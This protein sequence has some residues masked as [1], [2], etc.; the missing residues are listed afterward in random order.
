VIDL[1]HINL[2]SMKSAGA[3]GEGVPPVIHLDSAELVGGSYGDGIPAGTGE[4]AGEGPEDPRKIGERGFQAGELPGAFSVERDLDVLNAPVTGK[5][6]SPENRF[7]AKQPLVVGVGIYSRQ[8]L[9][10][11]LGGPFSFLPVALVILIRHFDF[12][13]P[14]QLLDTVKT[15]H[16]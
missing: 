6:D 13:D 11:P 8:Q 2:Y 10:L 12:P 5:G 9:H 4:F 14:F 1:G 3:G 7:A 15:R 16:Q